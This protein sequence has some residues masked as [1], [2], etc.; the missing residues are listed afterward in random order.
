MRR[1]AGCLAVL[2]LALSLGACGR[3]GSIRPPGP[4]DQVTHPRSYPSR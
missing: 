1:F 4:P 3:A 2:L